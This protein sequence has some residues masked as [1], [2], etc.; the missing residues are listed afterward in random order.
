MPKPKSPQCRV[1]H[2]L[3]GAFRNSCFRR[4]STRAGAESVRVASRSNRKSPFHFAPR[5]EQRDAVG[6][7]TGMLGRGFRLARVEVQSVKI[8][9]T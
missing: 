1:Q 5:F 6:T 9:A 4:I 8:E 2:E 3:R 7:N